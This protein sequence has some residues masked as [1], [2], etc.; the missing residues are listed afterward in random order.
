MK[1]MDIVRSAL[2]FEVVTNKENLATLVLSLAD[3]LDPDEYS[4]GEVLDIIIGICD[5]VRR[6][7][8]HKVN[9]YLVEAEIIRGNKCDQ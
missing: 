9:D 1:E 3:N 6:G 2:L 7:E 5:K 8:A 4:D